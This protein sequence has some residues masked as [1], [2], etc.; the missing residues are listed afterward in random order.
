MKGWRK[1]QSKAQ[2]WNDFKRGKQKGFPL[3]LVYL[4]LHLTTNQGHWEHLSIKGKLYMK[5]GSLF[6]LFV[7]HVEISQI[8]LPLVGLLDTLWES[9]SMSRE[10][11]WV[12][13]IMFHPS[14]EVIQYWTKFHKKNHLNQNQ[15]V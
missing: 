3:A 2:S 11:H 7:S 1:R 4:T 9:P 15:K 8:K 14:G 13:L 12:G 5:E 6:A 10:V